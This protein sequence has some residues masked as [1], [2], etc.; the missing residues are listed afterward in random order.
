[1]I[2][3]IALTMDKISLSIYPLHMW[4]QDIIKTMKSKKVKTY[5]EKNWILHLSLFGSYALWKSKKDS[6][7]DFL[8]EEKKGTLLSLFQL[9]QVIWFLKILL[10]KEVDLVEKSYIDNRIRKGI[11]AHKID[12]F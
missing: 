4:T 9:A 8:F 2:V 6:D 5:L 3:Y 11:L 1:M 7:I 12:I 10:K